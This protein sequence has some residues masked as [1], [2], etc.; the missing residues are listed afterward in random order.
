MPAAAALPAAAT[1]QA[2]ARSALL[3]HLDRNDA[4][5]AVG[6][7]LADLAEASGRRVWWDGAACTRPGHADDGTLSLPLQRLG[8]PLGRLCLHPG[9]DLA[10]D[11]AA[12]A[13]VSVTD[14]MAALRRRS[15]TNRQAV[16]QPGA[17]SG[18]ALVRAAL[19]GAGTFVWEWHIP[20]DRLGD[21]DEGFEQL[22]YPRS[23]GRRSQQD[24]DALIHP[25][26][27]D[28]NHQAYLR[29]AEGQ[30]DHYIHSYRARAAD[31]SWRWLQERGRIVEWT[32][33]GAPLRMVGVQADITAQREA[34]AAA[35]AATERLRKI[36]AHV[37][38]A[39]FQ[40]QRDDDGFGR[41]PY[42]SE[43]CLALF[44]VQPGDLA[45]DATRLLRRVELQQREAVMASIDASGATLQP[46]VQEF[47]VRW[48]D[49]AG[50]A[51]RW[52]RGSATPQREPDGQVLWHGYFEDLT[53]WHAL[54]RADHRQRVAEAAN[55]AKNEF[56]SRMSHELRTPLNAVLGFAQLMEMDADAPLAPSQQR[57][58]AL[59]RQSGEHLL[60]MIDDLLDL[61]SIEAGRLPLVPQLLDLRPLADDALALVQAAATRHDVTL[62][63]EGGAVQAWADRTRLRQVLINLLSNA[64]KYNRPGG[65]VRV[66]LLAEGGQAVVQVHDT[67]LGLSADDCAQLFQPF[68]RLGQAQGPVEGTGIGLAVTHHLVRLMGGQ[69]TVQSTPG[70]G[71][72][73]GVAL[74]MQAPAAPAPA[75]QGTSLP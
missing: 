34:E 31:G 65:Q 4:D 40:F 12:A 2:L 3:A 58:L 43:R 39:L 51:L 57:R 53:E 21:I 35:S 36:A 9:A 6:S 20:S 75:D 48:P 8:A 44:G 24:W 10:A 41:F 38:G 50:G 45:A 15:R 42:I 52:I 29:H 66:R 5:H 18:G 17:A 69:I 30:A 28:A 60:A 49:K 68:N 56:L 72:C 64:I 47:Q 22:G 19:R 26:D 27:R 13:L 7:L 62:V 16:D 37:P 67:G 11:A 63:C 59:I 32:A 73:F 33:D 71:S 61:T 46:W 74:P 54:V 1:L 23:P 14:V 70:I 55:L 25:D